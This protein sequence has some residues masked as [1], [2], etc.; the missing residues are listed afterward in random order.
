MS[1]NAQEIESALAFADKCGI[2]TTIEADGTRLPYFY[3]PHWAKG[4]EHER[5]L[6][7][8]ESLNESRSQ[9]QRLRKKIQ[10]ID[11]KYEKAAAE[12]RMKALEKKRKM[13]ELIDKIV[14]DITEAEQTMPGWPERLQRY[15]KASLEE[16]LSETSSEIG[17]KKAFWPAHSILMTND[18]GIFASGKL[19]EDAYVEMSTAVT[20]PFQRYEPE[21]I[22]EI[23]DTSVAQ[24][25]TDVA[26]SDNGTESTI[27][28]MAKAHASG[29]IVNFEQNTRASVLEEECEAVNSNSENGWVLI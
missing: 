1:M 12:T 7:W 23:V 8:Q 28:I 14:G 26:N 9:I 13:Q 24:S 20:S 22:T 16:W 11:S 3:V 25:L 4:E 27:A 17:P 5:N 21:Q 29:A 10:I 18:S 15:K 6:Q 2:P 19:L